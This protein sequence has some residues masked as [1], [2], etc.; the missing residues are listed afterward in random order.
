MSRVVK[1]RVT[2]GVGLL[3][4]V[5]SQFDSVWLPLGI[6][7]TALVT[8]SLVAQYRSVGAEVFDV[9][10]AD[11]RQI[12]S[13]YAI[14]VEYQKHGR[15]R[16]QVTISELTQSDVYEQVICDVRGGLQGDV[17]VVSGAPLNGRIEIS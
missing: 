14:D 5:L 16:P 4:I 3:G 15:R 8:I 9:T 1:G 17:R 7:G 6:V 10:T 13:E 11:W 2:L 12:A